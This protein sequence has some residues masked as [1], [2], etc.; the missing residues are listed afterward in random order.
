[1]SSTHMN[2]AQ[3]LEALAQAGR[4]NSTAAVMFHTAIA[5][6]FGLSATDWKC[7]EIIHRMGPIPAGELAKLSGLTSGAITGVVDR[8]EKE[9][10]ARR[11]HDPDDRRRVLIYPL[12]E[13]E[14]E[15]MQL[16]SSFQDALAGLYA[17]YS[18]EELAIILEYVTQ[19]TEVMEREASKMRHETA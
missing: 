15:A 19:A 10:I 2:R 8:L 17:R 9:R 18:D 13:R 14:D 3:L 4:E 5:G 7:A 6:R 1:M 12:Q 16:F 11:E